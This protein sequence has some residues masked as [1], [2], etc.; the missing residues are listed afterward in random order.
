MATKTFNVSYRTIIN[1]VKAVSDLMQVPMPAKTALNIKKIASQMNEVSADLQ[2]TAKKRAA[3]LMP[4][5]EGEAS[6]E[7]KELFKAEIEELLDSEVE[8]TGDK[9]SIDDLGM[10][11][12]TPA[13]L[14]ALEWLVTG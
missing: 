7:N 9:I 2:E 11:R 8:I 4:E 12:V 5:G 6:P 1:S 14:F 13:T 3:E 10:A